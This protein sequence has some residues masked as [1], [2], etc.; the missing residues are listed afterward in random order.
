MTT[1]AA[2]THTV[3][4]AESALLAYNLARTSGAAGAYEA[5]AHALASA[6][7]T[8]IGRRQLRAPMAR[9]A[10]RLVTSEEAAPAPERSQPAKRDARRPR[11]TAPDLDAKVSLPRSGLAHG[12]FVVSWADGS[13]TRISAGVW[14]AKRPGDRWAL[15]YQVANRL[16]RLRTR[17]AYL[18]ALP[19]ACRLMKRHRASG[20]C[21]VEIDS[22]LWRQLQ[23]LRPMP[24]LASIACET[25]GET[26]EAPA[27][28]AFGAGD[29]TTA[30]A[31]ERALA[32]PR[33]INR[34]QPLEPSTIAQEKAAPGQFCNA[35]DLL[36]LHGARVTYSRAVGAEFEA[37][38]KAAALTAGA[39]AEALQAQ[40]PDG[41]PRQS[42]FASYPAWA[43]AHERWLATWPEGLSSRIEEACHR[44]GLLEKA[45]LSLGVTVNAMAAADG[46]AWTLHRG[47]G[48]RWIDLRAP[49]RALSLSPQALPLLR[50]AA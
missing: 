2:F 47:P 45:A 33:P 16:R 27:G 23:A 34:P 40:R 46:L 31:L 21:G 20:P 8:E 25:T 48:G 12:A 30:A 11:T 43:E 32:E 17:N 50:F 38:A 29:A 39:E 42:A 49:G 44:R 7:Q 26:F 9:P 10:L 13:Q 6:L 15:A 41:Q 14:P 3:A 22:P 1:A 5:A 35:S 24:S 4:T 18:K 19:A 28:A 37:A 36:D